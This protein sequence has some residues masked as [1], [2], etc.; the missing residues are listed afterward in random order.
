MISETADFFEFSSMDN[1]NAENHATAGGGGAGKSNVANL[2]FTKFML[3][4]GDI[5]DLSGSLGGGGVEIALLLPAVQKAREAAISE[6][7][8]AFDELRTGPSAEAWDDWF[9]G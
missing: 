2:S 9:L 7:E 1:D 3:S 5:D 4:D 8:T 6:L